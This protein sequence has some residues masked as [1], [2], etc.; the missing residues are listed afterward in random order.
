[1][2]AALTD[3]SGK[4][5]CQQQ[6]RIDQFLDNI[7]AERGVSRNTL[8]AYERDLRSL[9]AWLNEREKL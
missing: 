1:M 2:D 3:V 5:Q 8:D 7:W 4:A 9:C 6:T